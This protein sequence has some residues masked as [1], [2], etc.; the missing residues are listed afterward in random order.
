[1]GNLLSLFYVRTQCI[2]SSR[3]FPFRINSET[4]LAVID[5]ISRLC[6]NNNDYNNKYN[7]I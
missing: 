2:V 4:E 6:A 1:M 5:K 7:I 3:L